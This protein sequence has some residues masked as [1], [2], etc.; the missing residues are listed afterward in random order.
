MHGLGYY[1]LYVG[2]ESVGFEQDSQPHHY[3]HL[4]RHWMQLALNVW[5]SPVVAHFCCCETA[6]LRPD[7][8]LQLP[9]LVALGGVHVIR[10]ELAVT[11][12][13]SIS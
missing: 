7:R 6:L 12:T 5:L 1:K 8:N 2:G 4:H 11:L 3:N 9:V 13:G 10:L